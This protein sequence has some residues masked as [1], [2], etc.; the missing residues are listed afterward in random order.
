[1]RNP[2]SEASLD[3]T[4]EAVLKQIEEQYYVAVLAE[5][6]IPEERIRKYGMA[7]PLKE[8]TS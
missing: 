7:L 5:R 2:G 4:A 3:D 6:G 1:M 8:R